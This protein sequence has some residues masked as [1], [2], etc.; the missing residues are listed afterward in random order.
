MG[1]ERATQFLPQFYTLLLCG[2]IPTEERGRA[3][4][5]RNRAPTLFVLFDFLRS[6]NASV[7][8]TEQRRWLL[9]SLGWLGFLSG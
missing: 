3:K 2:P 7:L 8:K 6:L 1:N 4:E 9:H 5:N